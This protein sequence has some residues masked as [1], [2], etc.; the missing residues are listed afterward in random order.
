MEEAVL[1]QAGNHNAP[2]YGVCGR[3]LYNTWLILLSAYK[4]GIM[5][6]LSKRFINSSPRLAEWLQHLVL[7][8]NK[9]AFIRTVLY[10]NIMECI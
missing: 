1:Q 4:R 8:L 9:P 2:C 6:S 10:N 5:K 7:Y 3:Q